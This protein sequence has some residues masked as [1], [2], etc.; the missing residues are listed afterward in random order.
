M[1]KFWRRDIKPFKG[2]TRRW[3][4]RLE[5]KP[6]DCWVGAFWKGG[7]F[8]GR[9]DEKPYLDVWVCI[10]PMLPIHYGWKARVSH[11]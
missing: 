5:W 3:F 8:R 4:I 9:L 11:G 6:R 1:T 10:I 7:T 2:M